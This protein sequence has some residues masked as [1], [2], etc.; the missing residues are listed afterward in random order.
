MGRAFLP[1]ALLAL[2]T[3]GC[4]PTAIDP[5]VPL[6]IEPVMKSVQ[7][8][9]GTYELRLAS[10]TLAPLSGQGPKVRLVAAIHIA[11]REYYRQVQRILD[12]DTITLFEGVSNKKDDFKKQGPVRRPEALYTKMADA[13]GLISQYE[14]IDYRREHFHNADLTQGEML[15][16]LRGETL[17]TPKPEGPDQVLGAPAKQAEAKY[18]ALTEVMNGGG[19]TGVM[20]NIGLAF[21]KHN[22]RLRAT[23][24]LGII[25]TDPTA[26]EQAMA[27]QL[28]GESG[29][30]IARLIVEERNQEAVSG[31]RR[32]IGQRKAGETIALFYGAAHLEG[33]ED[34]LVRRF[35]YVP[36]S[37]EWLVAV[38]VNPEEAGLT[39]QQAKEALKMTRK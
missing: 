21:I 33:I 23:M 1:L 13:L 11:D 31:L 32:F 26:S 9:E 22:P 2:L 15:A 37:T 10:R 19:L 6:K 3:A 18:Q 17:T 20:A 8:D 30:R 7:T 28:G 38:K 16:R 35:G 4:T 14:G 34:A 29:R 12:G 36:E 5:R 27:K 39:P 25:G 24:L